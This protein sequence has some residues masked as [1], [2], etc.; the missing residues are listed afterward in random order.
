MPFQVNFRNCH[1]K[2]L[3]KLIEK[4]KSDV[5]G[6]DSSEELKWLEDKINEQRH[7]RNEENE[8]KKVRDHKWSSSV[9]I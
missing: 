8:K 7:Y 9:T 2:L 6:S 5:Q 1:A 4:Y 3:A